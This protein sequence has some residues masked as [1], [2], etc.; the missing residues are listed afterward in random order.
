MSAGPKRLPCTSLLLQVGALAAFVLLAAFA[1][2][3]D[4]S[5]QTIPAPPWLEPRGLAVHDMVGQVDEEE[6]RGAI[7]VNHPG[8]G[9]LIYDRGARNGDQVEIHAQVVAS[10]VTWGDVS[11]TRVGCLG[12]IATYDT[13]PVASPASLMEIFADGLPVHGATEFVDYYPAGLRQPVAGSAQWERYSWERVEPTFADDGGLSLP[14]NLGC[15][16][17]L[18]GRHENVTARFRLTAPYRVRIE[19]LG[20]RTFTAE[21][22]IG[23]GATGMLDPLMQ[24]MMSRFPLRDTK[25]TLKPYDGTDHVF[26]KFP[27]AVDPYVALPSQYGQLGG[28]TYRFALL[29]GSLSVDHINSMAIPLDGGWQDADLVED[30]SLYLPYWPRGSYVS[31]PEYILPPGFAYDPCMTMTNGGCPDA[32]L[33]AIYAARYEFTVYYH[34]VT[35]ATNAGLA[36]VP[37]RQTGPGW[38]ADASERSGGAPAEQPAAVQQGHTSYFP[39]ILAQKPEEP[40]GCPCGWFD[41]DGAMV[42]FVPP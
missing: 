16:L 34:R 32:L 25:S 12:Q 15:S 38:S 29:N 22:Y 10:H 6:L 39:L 37:L 18:A 7:I 13:W 30:G 28:G 27:L 42:D 23:P 8:S 41:A 5:G 21:S 19:T 26:V 24:Q 20:K 33:D 14:P 36:R 35:R 40:T 9:V 17:L 2:A 3:T 4:A 31:G 1:S 11:Y